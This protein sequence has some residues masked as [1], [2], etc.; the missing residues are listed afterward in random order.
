MSPEEKHMA[1]SEGKLRVREEAEG[2]RH[3]G[4]GYRGLERP[5]PGQKGEAFQTSGSG[6]TAHGELQG[7]QG[8]T[9]VSG[10]A[11]GGVSPY[12]PVGADQ[13]SQCR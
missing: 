2:Q 9:E 11:L 12:I 10:A 8:Q 3:R 4:C 13:G 5:V 7:G 6:Q 1:L